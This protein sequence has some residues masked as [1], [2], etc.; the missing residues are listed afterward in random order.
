MNNAQEIG[1]N[2]TIIVAVL[3]YAATSYKAGFLLLFSPKSGRAIWEVKR[4][5]VIPF[6]LAVCSTLVIFSLLFYVVLDS[7]DNKNLYIFIN[8]LSVTLTLLHWILLKT[9]LKIRD[10]KDLRKFNE[11]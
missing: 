1:L 4:D 7:F 3:S 11:R 6:I 9:P 8:M 10:K 5:K 2:M